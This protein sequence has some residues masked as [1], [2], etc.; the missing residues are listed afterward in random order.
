MPTEMR[1]V[2]DRPVSLVMLVGAVL[3]GSCK[4][5]Q[6]E[7]VIA[8]SDLARFEPGANEQGPQIAF[9]VIHSVIVDL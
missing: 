7:L 3:L 8:Q 5:I 9:V 2:E 1:S 4:E 6:T